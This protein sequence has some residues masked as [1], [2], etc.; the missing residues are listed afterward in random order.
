MADVFFE[1]LREGLSGR[2]LD[3][4][5]VQHMEPDHAATLQLLIERYP[6]VTVVC[7]AI[8]KR[9]IGQFF[10]HI[11]GLRAKVVCDGETLD[12]GTRTLTFHTA[13]MVHWP[14]VIVTYDPQGAH[15]FQRGRIRHLW[16]A[17]RQPLRGR[18]G[19]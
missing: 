4:V 8:A 17:G 15:A 7:S 1:N 10:G 18:G 14:E 12:V 11:E 19:F 6:E 2:K 5:V 3:Y 16:R 13:A 9:M